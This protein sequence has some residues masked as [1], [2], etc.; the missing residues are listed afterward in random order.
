M[1]G[2]TDRIV[3]IRAARDILKIT[4]S[5]NKRFEVVPGGHAGVFAGS[6]APTHSWQLAA[7]WLA[8]LS[9]PNLEALELP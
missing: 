3:S 1:A 8:P 5:R 6:R 4:G 7:D 9:E 2:A